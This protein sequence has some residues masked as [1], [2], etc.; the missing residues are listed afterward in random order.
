[1]K[2]VLIALTI[3]S[4]SPLTY[5]LPQPIDNDDLPSQQLGFGYSGLMQ[6]PTDNQCLAATTPIFDPSASKAAIDISENQ[7]YTTISQKL[8]ID[9]SASLSV[10]LF[11]A[12]AAADYARDIE[13]DDYSL[14]F[15]YLQQ[16]Q[17]GVS[18]YTHT[19]AGVD[20]LN[21][22]GRAAYNDKPSGDNHS[23][24]LQACGDQFVQQVTYG[25]NLFTT[26]EINFKNYSDQQKFHAKFSSGFIIGSAT[27]DIQN[28]VKENHING[29]LKVMAYQEGG[30][31]TKLASIFQK[32]TTGHYAVTSCS[33]D[34]LQACSTIIQN[35]VSYAHDDFSNQIQ[36]DKQAKTFTGNV[37]PVDQHRISYSQ[38]IG[39]DLSTPTPPA[40]VPEARDDLTKT[41]TTQKDALLQVKHL[42][43]S[44]YASAYSF[45]DKQKL[46]KLQHDLTTNIALL[47][48]PDNG[49]IQCYLRPNQCITIYNRIKSVLSPVDLSVIDQFRYAYVGHITAASILPW[50]TVNHVSPNKGQENVTNYAVTFIPL[51]H[52]NYTVRD[53][54]TDGGMTQGWYAHIKFTSDTSAQF[55]LNLKYWYMYVVMDNRPYANEQYTYHGT[56]NKTVD[57]SY[58]ASLLPAHQHGSAL[59]GGNT[60]VNLNLV[61]MTNPEL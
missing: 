24:F 26:L 2:S 6:T 13:D 19:A 32:E 3:M 7:S 16:E 33:L 44:H 1:M 18:S 59:P 39:L 42:L 22:F 30:D 43:A 47:D 37:V 36:Y 56:L 28:F 48:S 53:I 29:T 20:A 34:N 55:L 4:L 49:A 5:A 25:A 31:P 23:Q 27:A 15:Y 17:L 14:N 35:I 41:Y 10:G 21:D 61:K 52:N 60:Y 58:S 38:G 50:W 9:S 51:G 8:N 12:S 54:P 46:E 45:S 11:S 57:S 40:G